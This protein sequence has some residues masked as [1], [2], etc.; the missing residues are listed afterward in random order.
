MKQFVIQEQLAQAVLNY[1]AT[2]PY[3]NVFQLIQ[4]LQTLQ[5]FQPATPAPQE[6]APTLTPEIQPEAVAEA[7]TETTN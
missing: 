6:P 5:E 7:K 2:C 4:G 1:L 3:A